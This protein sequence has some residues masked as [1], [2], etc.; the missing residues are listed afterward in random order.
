[1]YKR[2]VENLV[3][4]NKWV[5]LTTLDDRNALNST[6]LRLDTLTHLGYILVI[7][8]LWQAQ[9]PQYLDNLVCSY[10]SERKVIIEKKE[11]IDITTGYLKVLQWRCQKL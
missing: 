9:I 5:T 3:N 6:V 7:D 10:L 1:M 4:T 11:E 8:D 2:Q